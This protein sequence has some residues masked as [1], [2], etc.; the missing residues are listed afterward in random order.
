MIENIDDIKESDL[1]DILTV[2]SDEKVSLND[3]I[4]IENVDEEKIYKFEIEGKD[5]KS[6]LLLL[7]KVIDKN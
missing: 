5:L 1:K 4:N 7:S 2:T 6:F 3:N